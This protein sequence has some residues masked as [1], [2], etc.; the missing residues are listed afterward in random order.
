[1]RVAKPYCDVA[2]CWFRSTLKVLE[3][4]E[5][6]ARERRGSFQIVRL[7]AASLRPAEDWLVYYEQFWTRQIDALQ[8]YLEAEK[9]GEDDGDNK[10]G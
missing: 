2:G 1:M 4:A 9:E 5:L 7:N 8:S 3:A 10:R 6:I